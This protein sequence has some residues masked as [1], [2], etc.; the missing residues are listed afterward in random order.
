M[1]FATI[2]K[3]VQQ[4]LEL[5]LGLFTQF[6]KTPTQSSEDKKQ[7]IDEEIKKEE[8]GERPKW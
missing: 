6:K 3:L 4:A 5:F 8:D 1:T 2:I 7:M